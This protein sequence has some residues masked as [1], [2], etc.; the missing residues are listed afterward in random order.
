MQDPENAL[1]PSPVCLG[2]YLLMPLLAA[3]WVHQRVSTDV[4]PGASPATISQAEPIL[5]VALQ[6]RLQIL[7]AIT[8]PPLQQAQSPGEMVRLFRANRRATVTG[9]ELAAAADLGPPVLMS[10]QI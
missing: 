4:R 6:W 1:S 10:C 9:S 5:P 3:G 2:L 7:K 8:L